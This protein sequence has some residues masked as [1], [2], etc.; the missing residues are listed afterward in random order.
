MKSDW[1]RDCA[2]KTAFKPCARCCGDAGSTQISAPRRRRARRGLP[3]GLKAPRKLSTIKQVRGRIDQCRWSVT[4]RGQQPVRVPRIGYR[5]LWS[6]RSVPHRRCA[7]QSP[8]SRSGFLN[9]VLLADRGTNGIDQSVSLATIAL[10]LHAPTLVAF[11]PR[12]R[13]RVKDTRSDIAPS[14]YA[15]SGRTGRSHFD[16]TVEGKNFVRVHDF[17]A[18]NAGQTGCARL[19]LRS[20]SALRSRRAAGPGAPCGPGAPAGP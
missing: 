8:T 16:A 2:L 7:R 19:A 13:C 1:H 12:R 20:R 17:V 15:L 11:R 18:R 6:P 5:S 10:E 3:F 4:A 14:D 9:L